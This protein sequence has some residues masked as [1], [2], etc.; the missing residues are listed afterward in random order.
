M[1]ENQGKYIILVS[2][3]G[4]EF[5]VPA[6]HAKLSL[7]VE[8]AIQD[9]TQKV[10]T[11]QDFKTLFY[12]V[13][14][15]DI[16]KGIAPPRIQTPLESIDMTKITTC[17]NADF[18]DSI[19]GFHVKKL[20]KAAVNLRIDSLSELLSAKIAS[21]IKGVPVAECE[22]RLLKYFEDK[23]GDRPAEIVIDEMRS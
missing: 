14:F 8:Q 21:K 1:T 3:E 9:G 22:S 5:K 10:E 16:Q 13:K 7:V 6:N 2:S 15:L 18:V 17:A 11:G 4:K 20:F 12:L 23:I 19:G